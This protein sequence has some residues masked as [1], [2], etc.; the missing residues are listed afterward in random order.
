MANVVTNPTANQIIDAYDL[1]PAS[2]NTTQSLGIPTAEWLLT[3][4]TI[5]NINPGVFT[6]T[7]GNDYVTCVVGAATQTCAEVFEAEQSQNY[8]NGISSYVVFPSG[9]TVVDGFAFVGIVQ[10]SNPATSA[11]G[12]YTQSMAYANNTAVWGMNPLVIDVGK[13]TAWQSS[14]CALTGIEIDIGPGGAQKMA[15]ITAV[16]ESSG[17]IV[18]VT[19]NNTF[20]NSAGIVGAVPQVTDYV[21]F[22]GLT[23]ATW[24]NG[25][26]CEVLS[27]P[28]LSATQFQVLDATGHGTYSNASETGNAKSSGTNYVRGIII[29][30]GGSDDSLPLNFGA[31]TAIEISPEGWSWD[32][33]L[34]FD[35]KATTDYAIFLDGSPTET[36]WSGYTSQ[37]I[38]FQSYNSS[39]AQENAYI[40]S[41]QDGVLQL[42]APAVSLASTGINISDDFLGASANSSVSAQVQWWSDSGYWYANDISGAGQ[43]T[44]PSGS[45]SNPGISGL[46]TGATSGDGIVLYKGS[47]GTSPF[48]A[49]G[50][51]Y[52]WQLDIICALVSTANVCMRV[53]VVAASEENVDPPTGGM[54]VEFDTANASS[55]TEFTWVMKGAGTS[56]STTN[57]KAADTNYHHFRIRSLIAGT[58]GF[59][60][61]NGT[62]F[63]TTTDVTTANCTLFMQCLTRTSAAKTLN[64]DMV[65]YVARSGRT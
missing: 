43:I 28:G 22:E 39:G 24:L 38:G 8:T 52:G 41:D 57:S 62:E 48:G 12:I 11:A 45:F 36:I 29:T 2:S 47:H 30:G 17:N 59:T 6:S 32:M 40:F 19:A 42:S 49:L 46:E 31:A 3:S 56:Y 37:Q 5:N 15:T 61:D 20:F 27:P 4:F 21:I 25:Q 1:L 7:Q 64:L 58:I 23:G 50:S 10:T 18:T 35:N 53:G 9:G 51:N 14:G 16:S 33:G 55:D 34:V 13:D 60:I 26:V 44:Q 54:W 63:T 65:K